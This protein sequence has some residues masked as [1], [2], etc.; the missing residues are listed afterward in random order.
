MRSIPFIFL[1]F[2]LALPSC[3]EQADLTKPNV[4]IIFLDDSGW[5]D[6]EGVMSGDGS[7]K[8]LDP[9]EIQANMPY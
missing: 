9:V 3:N 1:C 5:A 8:H 2:C 4:V 7:W 6:F